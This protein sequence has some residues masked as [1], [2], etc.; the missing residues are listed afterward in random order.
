MN[1]KKEE[2]LRFGLNAEEQI[3][4]KLTEIFGTLRKLDKY[5]DFDFANEKFYV[6]VK[7]RRKTLDAFDTWYFDNRKRLAAKQQ[8]VK[9]F[10]CFFV[11]N[12]ED[13]IYLWE[14][15]NKNIITICSHYCTKFTLYILKTYN[16]TYL[17]VPS[18]H[19]NFI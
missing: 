2:D 4:P 7:T 16:N 15:K 19:K 8:I 12:L 5:N 3:Q 17:K 11:F 9:G 18:R 10:R 6:E 1:Q 13:G 14:Y